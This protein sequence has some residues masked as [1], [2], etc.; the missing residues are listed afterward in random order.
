MEQIKLTIRV[1]VSIVGVLPEI[2][3]GIR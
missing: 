3:N 2:R 1:F